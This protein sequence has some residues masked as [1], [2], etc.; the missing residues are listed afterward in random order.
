MS[1]IQEQGG[2]ESLLRWKFTV[3]LWEHTAVH[4]L[5]LPVV[6]TAKHSLSVLPWYDISIFICATELNV[7]FGTFIEVAVP[8]SLENYQ[9]SKDSNEYFRGSVTPRQ[10]LISH[11]K[12]TPVIWLFLLKCTCLKRLNSWL[13]SIITAT[14]LVLYLSLLSICL[15]HTRPTGTFKNRRPNPFSR[16]NNKHSFVYSAECWLWPTFQ[17]RSTA[18]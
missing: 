17:C 13:G 18:G 14:K 8:V 16:L 2:G 6:V 7:D 11:E 5:N 1:Q 3:G 4:F 9:L 12:H 15:H 10:K